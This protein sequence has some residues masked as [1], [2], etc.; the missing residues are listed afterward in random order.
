LRKSIKYFSFIFLTITVAG[1]FSMIT[2][3]YYLS[4]KNGFLAGYIYACV[5]TN[6]LGN[7]FCAWQFITYLIHPERRNIKYIV[8]IYCLIG[9]I[10]I[11]VFAPTV[12]NVL[13]TPNLQYDFRFCLVCFYT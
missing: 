3:F 13:Y 7:V 12:T 4:T 5:T 6:I 8:G 9:I 10:L 11:W 1:I 2:N